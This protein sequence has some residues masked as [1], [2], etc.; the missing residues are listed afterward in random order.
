MIATDYKPSHIRNGEGYL[1][2]RKRQIADNGFPKP[3]CLAPVR[4]HRL[5][6]DQPLTDT[7]P[8]GKSISDQYIRQSS[9]K[10]YR[11]NHLTGCR[12]DK[13]IDQLGDTTVQNLRLGV[14]PATD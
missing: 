9:K 3:C 6:A 5:E 14:D 8:T 7:A 12:D 13:Q 10:T 1:S 11:H 4:K 2:D